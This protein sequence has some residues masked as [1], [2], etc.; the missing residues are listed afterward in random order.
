M[1]IEL[2]AG[3]SQGAGTPVR[4]C[5]FLTARRRTRNRVAAVEIK[6]EN[7]IARVPEGEA[8]TTD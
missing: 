1:S 3:G 5:L 7:N 8:L 6:I 2:S 4:R